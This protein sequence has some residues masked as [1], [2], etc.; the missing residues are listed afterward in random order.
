MNNNITSLKTALLGFVTLGAVTFGLVTIV[1]IHD[2]LRGFQAVALE[3]AVTVLAQGVALD[4]ARSLERDWSALQAV[5][6]SADPRDLDAIALAADVLAGDRQ[7]ISWAGYAE[8]DAR[9]AAASGDMLVGADITERLWF[10]RGL[11]GP[12]AGD[13]RDALLLNRLLG[14]TDEEPIRFLDLSTPVRDAQ[15]RVVGVFALHLNFGWTQTFLA[16][17][18]SVLGID[19]FLVS[20]DGTVTFA[21]DGSGPGRLDLP[22]MRAARSGVQV[23]GQEVWPDGQTYLTT[24][25]PQVAYRDL[26]SFGWRLVARISPEALGDTGATIT[27]WAT[28]LFASGIATLLA[29]TAVFYRLFLAPLNQLAYDATRIAE[30]EDIPPTETRSTREAAAISEALVRLQTRNS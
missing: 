4:L 25:V 20:Q 14:G 2:R 10:Q 23:S 19:L 18:A 9:I 21:S 28:L 6:E 11:E 26:P 1:A 8:L 7:R 29:M 27:R 5:A 12:F 3:S 15:D 16:E 13:A 30:G 24:V 22:S 17:T